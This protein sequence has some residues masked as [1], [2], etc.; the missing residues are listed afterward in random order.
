ML[1]MQDLRHIVYRTTQA[2]ISIDNDTTNGK[3]STKCNQVATTL[4]NINDKFT[5]TMEIILRYQKS[6]FGTISVIR[7]KF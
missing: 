3:I 5:K 6:H 1:E 2:F 4:R 7:I